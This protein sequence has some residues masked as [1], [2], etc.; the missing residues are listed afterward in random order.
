MIVKLD[1][2]EKEVKTYCVFDLSFLYTSLFPDIVHNY[3][4]TYLCD[5]INTI[6]IAFDEYLLSKYTEVSIRYSTDS[7]LYYIDGKDFN[8]ILVYKDTNDQ[9]VLYGDK[10]TVK[11]LYEFLRK[12]LFDLQVN[13]SFKFGD[14]IVTIERNK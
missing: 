10:R 7:K 8:N 3:S 11:K 2:F 14:E 5:K 12:S 13:G 6:Y 1:D 9:K 4:M